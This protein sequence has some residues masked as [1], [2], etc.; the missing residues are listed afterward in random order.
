MVEQ[1]SAPLMGS[2]KY[3]QR[4]SFSTI[5]NESLSVFFK[6][7]LRVTLKDPRQ[8]VYFL[9]TVNNQRKAAR[10]RTRLEKEGTRVPPIMLISVTDSCNLHC[11]G[12]YHRA[13]HHAAGPEMTAEKVRGILQ[14][15]RDLGIS[16]IAFAGGEPLVRRDIIAV[17][18]EFPEM[19]FLVFTNGTLL[20]DDLLAQLDKQRNF[21]PVIS[22]EGWQEETDERRGEG[23]YDRLEKIIARVKTANLFWSVSLTVT[24]SNFESVTDRNFVEFLHDLGCK[25]FF[26]VEYT[27]VDEDTAD[28]VVTDEQRADL[29]RIRDGYRKDY[30]AL[31]VAVPGDEEEVD[32]PVGTEIVSVAPS[33]SR[34]GESRPPAELP[35]PTS[36]F[37]F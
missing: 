36:T 11:K 12:C 10:K 19:I 4:K 13:L 24:R 9:Q 29:L 25:L 34:A 33:V 16:F 15:A 23:V 26:F 28:W 8:A 30:P 1:S 5:M 3:S 6:D 14:E 31:F 27:P 22:L 2:V 18:A 32:E 17:T 21:V 7:A 37:F 20:D 35:I